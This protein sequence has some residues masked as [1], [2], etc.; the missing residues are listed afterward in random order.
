L[1]IN[2]AL[3]LLRV[4]SVE[5]GAVDCFASCALQQSKNRAELR[6]RMCLM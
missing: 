3:S 2:L 4:T 6:K 1:L 5:F